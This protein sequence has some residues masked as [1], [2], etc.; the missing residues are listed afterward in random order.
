MITGGDS[1]ALAI[2]F[3][4]TLM[5]EKK[6]NGKNDAYTI[7]I[8]ETVERKLKCLEVTSHST[9]LLSFIWICYLIHKI[10]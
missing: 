4:V 10:Y 3:S 6:K 9:S 8:M 7:E 1:L 2:L 5:P